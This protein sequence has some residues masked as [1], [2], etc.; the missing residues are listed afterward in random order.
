MKDGFN[1]SL[2]HY[3]PMN[4]EDDFSSSLIYFLVTT[5]NS[6]LLEDLLYTF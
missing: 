3:L 5:N 2:V 4:F 6:F 1:T